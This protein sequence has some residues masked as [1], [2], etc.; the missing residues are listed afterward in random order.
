MGQSGEHSALD[1][2]LA[3]GYEVLATNV[4]SGNHEVDIVAIDTLH[5]ELAFV[6]VKTRHNDDYGDPSQA[7]DRNKIRSMEIVAKK[8]RHQQHLDLDYRFDIL[9]IIPGTIH[10]Y[11]NV[12]WLF[13]K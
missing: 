2:L 5:R 11:E 12:T 8:F 6:E 13:K 10:H 7:V 3:K 9:A 4:Q 1:F